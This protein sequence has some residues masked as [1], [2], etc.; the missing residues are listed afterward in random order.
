M[1]VEAVV[2]KIGG[3]SFKPAGKGWIAPI[4]DL[5]KRLKP[6]E[7]LF[8]LLAPERVRV[9]FRLGHQGLIGL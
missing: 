3:A 6:M 5:I 4:E 9:S 2:G 7:V 8:C 1:T